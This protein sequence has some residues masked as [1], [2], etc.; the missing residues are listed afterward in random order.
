MNNESILDIEVVSG[1]EIIDLRDNQSGYISLKILRVD[2]VKVGDKTTNRY[3]SKGIISLI[4][5]DECMPTIIRPD[6]TKTPAEML[7]TPSSVLHRKNISQ[8]YEC[9]LTKCIKAIYKKVTD[10][11]SDGDIRSCRELL[12]KF[13]IVYGN[14]FKNMTDEEFIKYH[15]LKGLFAYQMEVGFFSK[16]SYEQTLEW[17]KM[18]NI[19]ET[20]KVFCPD[21]VIV[22]TEDGVRGFSPESFKSYKGKGTYKLY[23]LG[24]LESECVAGTEYIMK[25]WKQASYDGKVTS[26]LLESTEPI[27]GRGKYRFEGQKIGE[28]ELWVLI[29]NGIERFLHDQSDTLRTSQYQFLNELL[30]SGY[31]I[32]DNQGNPLLSDTRTKQ[33]AL[34]SL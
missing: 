5:P 16:V 24:E 33:K 13:E 3:G 14:R 26:E 29:G 28:M 25:L 22:E 1:D 34:E 8:L 17:M 20:D 31:Y 32:E 30:L 27:M 2:N 18:L 9:A 10:Y 15:N 23:E 21:V 6:G 12:D 4:L 7:L 11:I 19:S